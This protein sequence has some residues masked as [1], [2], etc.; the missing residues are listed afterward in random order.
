MLNLWYRIVDFFIDAKDTL[1]RWRS[2][3]DEVRRLRRDIT[4]LKGSAE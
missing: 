1:N 2:L 4:R 3:P